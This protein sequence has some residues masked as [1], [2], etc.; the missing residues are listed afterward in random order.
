MTR[1]EL[2]G[3]CLSPAGDYKNPLRREDAALVDNT[4]E[5]CAKKVRGG[6]QKKFAGEKMA[7]GGLPIKKNRDKTEKAKN[8][9]HNGAGPDKTCWATA[10]WGKAR[11]SN[12]WR[13]KKKSET[14]MGVHDV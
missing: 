13:K 12:P 14:K 3:L 8:D 7:K 1:T 10:S 6:R 4:T 2:P 9:V 5:G 11:A